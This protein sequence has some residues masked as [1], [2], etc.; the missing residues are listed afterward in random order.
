MKLSNLCS[1]VDNG[2]RIYT[3]NTMTLFQRCCLPAASE[4]V[5]GIQSQKG[6]LLTQALAQLTFFLTVR[7][8]KLTCEFLYRLH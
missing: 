8:D 1:F 7:E 3:V 4:D 5:R 6:V 2:D